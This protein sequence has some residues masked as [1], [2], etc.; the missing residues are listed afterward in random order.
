VNIGSY[1]EFD[2]MGSAEF[3]FGAIPEAKKA[4]IERFS[5]EGWPEPERITEGSHTAWYV[6]PKDGKA[7]AEVWFHEELASPYTG[8]KESSH[9]QDSYT[10][11]TRW[12]PN[13]WFC[14]D[15]GRERL[16]RP[17]GPLWGLFMTKDQARDFLRGLRGQ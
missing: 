13:G 4:L 8:M 15:G 5:E 7:M 14:I 16:G 17:E 11:P 12:S 10:N 9:L 2:Y 6:G 3:E 1:F